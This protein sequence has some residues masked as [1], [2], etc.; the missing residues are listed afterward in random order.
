[1]NLVTNASKE[2]EAVKVA[3][4]PTTSFALFAEPVSE[5]TSST[6]DLLK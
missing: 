3:W 5:T 4:P 1:M 6:K 2:A